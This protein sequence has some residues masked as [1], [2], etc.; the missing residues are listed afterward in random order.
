M[1][2]I[3]FVVLSLCFALS[4]LAAPAT[5]SDTATG[6]KGVCA[7]GTCDAPTE[8]ASLTDGINLTSSPWRGVSVW[9]CADN[10]QTLSGAGTLT[11]YSRD[12]SAALWAAAPLNN[13]SVT[14]SG[15][16]CQDLGVFELLIPGGRVTWVPTGVTVS[17]GGVTVYIIRR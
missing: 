7:S 17:G 2:K 15:R 13:L 1:K 6:V 9:V 10:A 3:L 16:R 4:A 8:A 11:A 5:Y 12:A 14:S